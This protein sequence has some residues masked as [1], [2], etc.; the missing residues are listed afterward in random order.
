MGAI[1]GYQGWFATVDV[2][3]VA[4]ANGL[5]RVIGKHCRE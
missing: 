4:L 2:L 1:Y 5:S 3:S